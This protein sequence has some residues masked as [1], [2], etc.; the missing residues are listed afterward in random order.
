MKKKVG[1]VTKN[2]DDEVSLSI[3]HGLDVPKSIKISTNKKGSR[4]CLEKSITS[5]GRMSLAV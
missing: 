4:V 3:A 2:E 1:K 5:S